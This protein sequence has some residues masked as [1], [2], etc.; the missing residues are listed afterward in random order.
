MELMSMMIK[1]DEVSYDQACCAKINQR[2]M[3]LKDHIR[4][5]GD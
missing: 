4:K 2:Q 5:N 1:V 3:D